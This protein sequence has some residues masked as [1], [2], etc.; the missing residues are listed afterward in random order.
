MVDSISQRNHSGCWCPWKDGG[1]IW[2]ATTCDGSI[3]RNNFHH[4]VHAIQLRSR[5]GRWGFRRLTKIL[6][7]VSVQ[8]VEEPTPILLRGVFICER[9]HP[10]CVWCEVLLC[11]ICG[12]AVEGPRGVSAWGKPTLVVE[13]WADAEAAVVVC[14]RLCPS[15]GVHRDCGILVMPWWL[16]D[17]LSVLPFKVPP[18]A[19]VRGGNIC[20]S[21]VSSL[22]RS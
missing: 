10:H 17:F 1:Y 20:G 12:V 22:D 21:L 4:L 11:P 6:S 13:V 2:P 14:V 3:G 8:R 5:E 16:S 19:G 9:F 7:V 18:W 15:G